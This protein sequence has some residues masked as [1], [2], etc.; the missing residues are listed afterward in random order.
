MCP[1]LD[2]QSVNDPLDHIMYSRAVELFFSFQLILNI[3]LWFSCS[4]IVTQLYFSALFG[5]ENNLARAIYS[6]GNLSHWSQFMLKIAA[7]FIVRQLGNGKPK[8]QWDFSLVKNIFFSRT[9]FVV[10]II[11]LFDY[12]QQLLEHSESIKRQ[13]TSSRWRDFKQFNDSDLEP[14]HH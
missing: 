12:H 10:S 9:F 7:R 11:F 6:S 8:I 4:W 14:L 5:H 2:T 1:M 13:T 3:F